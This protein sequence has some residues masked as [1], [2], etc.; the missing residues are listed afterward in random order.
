MDSEP[1]GVIV[2][3][4]SFS[5]CLFLDGV[6]KVEPGVL[7]LYIFSLRYFMRGGGLFVCYFSKRDGLY[8]SGACGHKISLA[9]C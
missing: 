6:K 9:K 4:S 8:V 3:D 7:E 2:R 1:R 5:E